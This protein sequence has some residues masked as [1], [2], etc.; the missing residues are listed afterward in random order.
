MTLKLPKIAQRWDPWMT[1]GERS[2]LAR[3]VLQTRR[4]KRS[5]V[6]SGKLPV[7]LKPFKHQIR[8]FRIGMALDAAA[9]LMEQRTGKTLSAIAIAGARYQQG[10]VQRVIIG[11]PLSV[12]DVWEQA[13][14]EVAD[15]PYELIVVSAKDLNRV[16]RVDELFK[17][18]SRLQVL[19]INYES[20]WRVDHRLKRWKP[21]MVILDESQRIKRRS[22]RQS[23]GCHKLGRITQYK[24]ILSGTP[25]GKNPIDLFSQYLFLNPAIFGSQL[26]RFKKRYVIYG[27]YCNHKIIGYRRLKLLSRLAHSIAYRV[28]RK[29]V[30]DMPP[31]VDQYLYVH[32]K[33]SRRVY[34]ELE[35][36][37]VTTVGGERVSTP[38]VIT[39]LLRLQ[40]ITGGF[41]KTDEGDKF[42]NVGREKLDELKQFME[43][44]PEDQKIVIFARFL[45]EI[46]AIS[47]LMD[48]LSIT[49]WCFTGATNKDKILRKRMLKAFQMKRNPRALIVQIQTGGL[50]RDFTAASTAVFY[51]KNFSWLDYDQARSRLLGS[52]QKYPVNF[53]HLIAKG[54]IEETCIQPALK[55]KR[56]IAELV[57]DT[58]N[59]FTFSKKELQCRRVKKPSRKN[60]S[61]SR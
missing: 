17:R 21:D 7:K 23:R 43:G 32:L 45:P 44:Y 47:K 61:K 53:I 20:L 49:N 50:G 54:T 13:F 1:P 60:R 37:L 56:N 27:G 29:Q 15:F 51:S 46:Q 31:E 26:E 35:K 18:R 24:L 2:Y 30:F 39:Q 3:Q 41:L 25:I 22:A 6:I 57:I 10:Q 36:K 52:N 42:V 8:A 34:R 48:D 59:S 14:K 40:Q 58:F 16:R 9:L 5:R 11:M 12:T 33:K 38:M 28:T 55:E 4:I 19:I